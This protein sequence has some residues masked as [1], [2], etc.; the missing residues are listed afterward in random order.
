MIV[1][2]IVHRLAINYY[3]PTRDQIR[4]VFPYQFPLVD[5]RKPCLLRVRNASRSEL[6]GQ[7]ILVCF[8]E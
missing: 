1:T 5:D 8:L 2:D 6:D 4:D 7:C 3:L